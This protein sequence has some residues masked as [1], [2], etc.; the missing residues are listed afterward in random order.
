MVRIRA[1]YETDFEKSTLDSPRC[2]AGIPM[3]WVAFDP[4]WERRTKWR[5]RWALSHMRWR[6]P[7]DVVLVGTFRTDGSHAHMDMRPFEFNVLVVEAI[8]PLGSFRELP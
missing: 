1:V 2:A 3:V 5:V 7:K 8:R 6:E 4:S